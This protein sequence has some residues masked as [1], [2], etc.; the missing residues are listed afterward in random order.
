V[1]SAPRVIGNTTPFPVAPGQLLRSP[2]TATLPKQ[3]VLPRPPSE[4]RWPTVNRTNG[5]SANR[6][7]LHRAGVQPRTATRRAG[8]ALALWHS[9]PPVF[10]DTAVRPARYGVSVNVSNISKTPPSSEAM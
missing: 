1:Q 7:A 4:W 10:I 6:L 9:P 5:S 2:S 3:H 8:A